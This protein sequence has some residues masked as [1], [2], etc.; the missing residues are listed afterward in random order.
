[1]KRIQGQQILIAT[2]DGG[3]SPGRRCRQYDIVVAIAPNCRFERIG[4]NERERLGEQSNRVPH[5]YRALMKFSSQDVAQ[6]VERRSGRN[7]DVMADAVLQ[8]LAADAARDEGRD[9]DVR[10]EEQPHETRLNTSSSV[11][12]P[13]A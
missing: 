2:D 6:L 10:V 3:T 8:K 11:K 13:C 9:E 7:D 4:S 5:V 12:M 1:V